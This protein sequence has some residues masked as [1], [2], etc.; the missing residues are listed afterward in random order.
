MKD[1]NRRRFSRVNIRWAARLDF[2]AMEYKRFVDNV[3]L[4]GFRIDGNFQLRTNDLCIIR[5]TPSGI[6]HTG[7]AVRAVGIISRISETDMA[8]EFLSMKLDS[9]FFLK[10]TLLYKAIDPKSLGK[11]FIWSDIIEHDKDIVYFRP[12]NMKHLDIRQ[13][14][15]FFLRKK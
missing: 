4:S 3:S 5:L 11:E 2:G 10:T 8:I 6:L 13:L 9:F 1:E 15:N 14:S 12:Y 7:D